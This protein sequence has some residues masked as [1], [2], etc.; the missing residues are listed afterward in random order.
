MALVNIIAG[1]NPE[2]DPCSDSSASIVLPSPLPE[3]SYYVVFIKT[4]LPSAPYASKT[5]LRPLSGTPS[6]LH[7][8]ILL[9]DLTLPIENICTQSRNALA[10][11]N[12]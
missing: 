7:R 2:P 4:D 3:S 11:R 12:M 1:L 10:T 9:R 5:A 6:S 8:S